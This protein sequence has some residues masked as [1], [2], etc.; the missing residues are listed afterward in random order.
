[1]DWQEY[2]L[3]IAQSVALKSKDPNTKVGAIVV[4]KRNRIIGSGYNGMPT[5]MEETKELWERPRKYSFVCH[6]EMNAIL[7]K[8]VEGCTLYI[9]HYPC[10]VCA[11]YIAQAGIEMVVV[12]KS[13]LVDYESSIGKTDEKSRLIFEECGIVVREL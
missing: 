12:R 11:R 1:M 3:N 6:A 7:N 8:D 9:T 5:G 13:I 2:Y 10:N 4:N